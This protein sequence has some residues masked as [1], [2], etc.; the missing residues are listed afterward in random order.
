[1]LILGLNMFHADS[2]AAIVARWKNSL[3]RGGRA[4]EP[5]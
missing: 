1:M 3:C 4:A 2:S 5:A